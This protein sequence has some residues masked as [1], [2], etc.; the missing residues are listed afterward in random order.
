MSSKKLTILGIIAVLMIIWA[1]VQSQISNKPTSGPD[2][3][4][5][6]IQGLDP[7]DIGSIVLGTGKDAV[8]LKRQGSGFVAANKDNYSADAS[9]INDLITS[10]LDIKTVELY[11]DNPANHENL[12]VTEE[13]ARNV[14]KF[15]KP[16]SELLVG[17]VIGKSK[18]QGQGTFVRLASSNKVYVTLESPWIRDDPMDYIE[19]ELT[20]IE[21]EDIEAVTVSSPNEVYTLKKND[22]DESIILENLPEGKKLR[23]GVHNSVFN[24]LTNLRFDDVK[25]G[26]AADKELTFDKQF[27][28]R[29]KNSTVYT[30]KIA[31]KDNKTYVTCD[32][33]FTDKTPVTKTKGEV[34]SEEE[35]K[36]KEAKLLARDKAEEF[37][38]KHRGWIYQIPDYKAENL[39]KKL[40]D[41]IEDVEKPEEKSEEKSEET[42]K[43]SDPNSNVTGEK[44]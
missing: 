34:E 9:K 32:A 24:A 10:C 38:E 5:E 43:T 29:L 21:R 41:L 28:C 14:I 11:T 18:E 44:G 37:S 27:V 2:I 7:A 31:Q 33:E 40:S 20:S 35:L 19:Q 8:T 3:P 39:T 12:E 16:D 30:I 1:V 6:L 23:S 13:N 42:E 4:A 22:E 25:K 17:V 36:K 26:P 15:L